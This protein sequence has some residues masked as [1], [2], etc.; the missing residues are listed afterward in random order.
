MMILDIEKFK[1]VNDN[2][3]H[4]VGDIVLKEFTQIIKYNIRQN[5]IFGRWGGEEFMI[6]APNTSLENSI[7]LAQKLRAI[8]QT[9]N[10]EI[11]GLKTCSI[12]V[13]E[14][15]IGDKLEDVIKRADEALYLAKNSG[16]NRVCSQKDIGENCR[17]DRRK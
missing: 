16:R 4:Q 9:H 2:Y 12:G 3:G 6:I 5:D 13:S 14:Y 7:N 1:S 17:I 8:V 11:I 15:T 10:F